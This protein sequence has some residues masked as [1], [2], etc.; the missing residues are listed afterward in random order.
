MSSQCGAYTSAA[1]HLVSGLEAAAPLFSG[2]KTS[3]LHKRSLKNDMFYLAPVIKF[4]YKKN[5]KKQ[6]PIQK[7]PD[8]F[9]LT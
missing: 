4:Y 3:E 2:A 8:T 9:S 1:C 5:V 7:P 6:S